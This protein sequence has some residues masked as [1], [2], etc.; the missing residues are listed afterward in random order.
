MVL[1]CDII[2]TEFEFQSH[3]YIYFRTKTSRKD[4]NPIIHQIDV[5][6]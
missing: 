2:I 5:I 6:W 3:R 4:M 1:D